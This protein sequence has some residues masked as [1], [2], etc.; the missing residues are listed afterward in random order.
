MKLG[1]SVKKNHEP[2]L[3]LYEDVG[4]DFLGLGRLYKL[5]QLQDNNGIHEEDIQTVTES[6]TVLP[7]R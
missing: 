4:I 2:D 7:E 3:N 6:D 5:K 1:S